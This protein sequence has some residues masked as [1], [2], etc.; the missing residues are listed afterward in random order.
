MFRHWR[1]VLAIITALSLSGAMAA[2]AAAQSEKS[3]GVLSST[4][5]AEKTE[6]GKNLAA[7]TEAAKQ[8]LLAMDTNKSGKVSKEE[9]MKCMGQSSTDWTRTIEG[10][11]T[12]KS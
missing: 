3:P 5:E 1:I 8:R 10:N 7:A 4:P 6:R 2:N 11:W 9:R 12:S